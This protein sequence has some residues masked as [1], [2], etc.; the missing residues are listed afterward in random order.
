[1]STPPVP[2]DYQPLNR[3]SAFSDLTGP[4]YARKP[5]DAP[6]KLGLR[7]EE[8]HL[9]KVGVAHGGALMTL[10]DNACGDTAIG[11]FDEPVSMVTVSMNSEFLSPAVLGDWVE[12]ETRIL[13]RGG[14]L[15]FID[16]LLLV[17]GRP[18]FHASAVMARVNPK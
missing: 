12:S 10:A 17:E 1:M 9:N 4:Y 2:A 15:I 8:Q 3:N 11:A 6:L 7:I 5:E 16:C 14:R 13:R 18:V